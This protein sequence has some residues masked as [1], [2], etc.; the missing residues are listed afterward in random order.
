MSGA[1][2]R[3]RIGLVGCGRW[4]RLILRDL[5]ALGCPVHVVARS[6]SSIANARGGGAAS[7]VPRPKDL[8]AIDGV[9]V[10]TPTTTHAAVIASLAARDA[11]LFVEKPLVADPAELPALE[12]LADRLFVM[13]KWRYHA[14]VL[15]L[16]A[17]ARSGRLG[18]IEAVHTT[19]WGFRS[20]RRDID[21][22]WYLAPHD[23]AIVLEILGGIPE[24]RAARMQRDET[25]RI[26]GG[27]ALLGDR[28]WVEIAFSEARE[29]HFREIR[30][31]GRDAIAVLPDSYS[32][33]LR[34]HARPSE[35][36]ADPPEPE[37]L[38]IDEGMPL[39]AELDAFVR[40]VEG[41]PPP[42]SSFRDARRAIEALDRIAKL[43]QRAG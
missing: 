26:V 27:V 23:L 7:V 39:L 4:G 3:A 37:L 36:R 15:A 10:A 17:L 29:A 21:A 18:A 38:P 16:A 34:L 11:P 5:V 24:P 19:R 30:V 12:P 2:A 9:V 1:A 22:L 43:G 6:E 25:G 33:H 28:P 20:K 35:V 40:H 14:G 31:H 13:D 42:K 41:G 8:P 32:P